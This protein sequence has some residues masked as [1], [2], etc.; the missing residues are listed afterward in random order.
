MVRPFQ[1]SP[2]TVSLSAT[3][4]AVFIAR[5]EN[6]RKR[7]NFDNI[8]KIYHTY[9]KNEYSR[10]I[11]G[12]LAINFYNNCHNAEY[13]ILYYINKKSDNV[14]LSTETNYLLLEGW[15]WSCGDS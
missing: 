15:G 5:D 1:K 12:L 10:S 2:K 4:Y 9:S 3:S 6:N 7:V 11:T 14:I 8:V 13:H